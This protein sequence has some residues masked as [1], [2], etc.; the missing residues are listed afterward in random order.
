MNTFLSRSKALC[1]SAMEERDLVNVAIRV[2]VWR[3]RHNSVTLEGTLRAG[4]IAGKD[5]GC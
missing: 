4:A 1:A 2:N 3:Y 5:L